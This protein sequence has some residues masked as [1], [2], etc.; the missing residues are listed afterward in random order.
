[1]EFQEAPAPEL[2]EIPVMPPAQILPP[3]AFDL[4]DG[5]IREEIEEPFD[6]VVK[7]EIDD[8]PAQPIPREAPALSSNLAAAAARVARRL[9]MGRV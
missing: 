2:P 3:P 9:T 8:E 6:G 1:M 5:L 7:E 4:A